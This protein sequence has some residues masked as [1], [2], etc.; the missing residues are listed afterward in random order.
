[1]HLFDQGWNALRDQ[2][3]ANQKKAGV[4]PQ[5]AKLTPRPDNLLKK[6]TAS[7]RRKKKLFIRQANAY[8]AY[9]AYTDNGIGRVIPAGEDNAGTPQPSNAR[10]P[11]DRSRQGIRLQVAENHCNAR[12]ALLIRPAGAD[13]G[14]LEAGRAGHSTQAPL[15]SAPAGGN[16]IGSVPHSGFCREDQV[17]GAMRWLLSM[18]PPLVTAQSLIVQL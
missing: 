17:H 15:P 7:T 14:R 18:R 9:F 1:M 3:F 12:P 8:A 2:I 16:I 6:G 11:T 13:Q 5:A 4:I 10:G